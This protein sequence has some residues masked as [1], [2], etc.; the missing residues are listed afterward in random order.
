[1]TGGDAV[2][3]AAFR[4][5]GVLRVNN[6]EDLFCMADVLEKQPRPLGP[7]LTIIL[8]VEQRWI[9]EVDV[10][11][12]F[13][14]GERI[15]ALDARVIVFGLETHEEELPRLAIRPYPAQYVNTWTTKE[16][17]PVTIRVIRPEDEPLMVAFHSTLSDRSVELRYMQ[18]LPLSRRVA[19]ERL[20][21]I[22]FNDYDRELALVAER[23]NSET[24]KREI[25][26]VG[27]LSKLRRRNEAELAVVVSDAYQG[28]GLGTELLSRLV[29]VARDEKQDRVVGYIAT[30]NTAMLHI[31]QKL[32]FRLHRSPEEAQVEAFIDL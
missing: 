26:A 17:M 10:N 30:D 1:M 24:G 16:G 14:S 21:R 22:C 13:V 15:L 2:L 20:A 29:Q 11:P 19:H 8:V 4:R 3:D 31:S 6:I 32:G 9:R 5:C 27:R 28:H 23:M 12:L 7:H 25:V 18:V